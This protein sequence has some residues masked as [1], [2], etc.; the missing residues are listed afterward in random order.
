MK[1]NKCKKL[2]CNLYNKKYHVDPIRSLKQ[3]VNNG[4]KIKKIH[5]VLKFNQRAWIKSYID[6]NT[7]L[8][9][10]AKNDFK[11]DFFKLMKNVVYGKTMEN[12]RKHR[13]IKSVNNDKKKK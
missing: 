9:K 3:A 10:N 11:K 8:R 5:K 13:I 6:M 7:D 1:V 4:L 2:V 12:V